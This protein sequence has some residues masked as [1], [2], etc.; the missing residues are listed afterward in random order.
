MFDLRVEDNVM[1]KLTSLQLVHVWQLHL[2]DIVAVHV[3]KD[4]FDHYDTQLH[5]LPELVHLLQ[6]VLITAP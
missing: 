2:G 4:I 1:L 5:L 3:H 6:D